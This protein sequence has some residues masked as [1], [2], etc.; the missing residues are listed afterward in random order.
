MLTDPQSSQEWFNRVLALDGAAFLGQAYMLLLGRSIDPD[1]LQ[2]YSQ[3]LQAG[4]SKLTIL[5][6]IHASAEGRAYSP[7][8]PDFLSLVA[9]APVSCSVSESRWL[10]ADS[11]GGGPVG[12]V[13][14]I[15]DL[16]AREDVAF[17][18]MAFLTLLGRPPD[19]QGGV[20]YLQ[21]LRAGATKMRIVRG[22]CRSREGSGR[23]CSLP[24]LS[25]A[26]FRH[27][28]ANNPLTG[29]LYRAIRTGDAD[30]PVECRLR[31]IE[32]ILMRTI[33]ER[34]RVDGELDAAAADVA[35]LLRDLTARRTS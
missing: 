30:S 25:A 34:K 26:I 33:V 1:G 4:T 20:S 17:I 3:H 12:L 23:K 6:D 2:S 35:C 10:R 15:D 24:G 19:P 5:A 8:I 27:W 13:L 32:N 14:H 28:L 11:G 7:N 22:L 29:W 31:R 16:L 18:E 9:Q 21:L